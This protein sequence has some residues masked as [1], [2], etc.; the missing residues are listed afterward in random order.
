MLLTMTAALLRCNKRSR[1]GIVTNS[2]C[3]NILPPD[4]GLYTSQTSFLLANE[5][6]PRIWHIDLSPNKAYAAVVQSVPGDNHHLQVLYEQV[7]DMQQVL[8]CALMQQVSVC[9]VL[10]T[11]WQRISVHAPSAWM[12]GTAQVQTF[13]HWRSGL[14][15]THSCALW[16]FSWQDTCDSVLTITKSTAAMQCNACLPALLLAEALTGLLLMPEI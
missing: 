11:A 6:V 14:S 7:L 12:Q 1:V 8:V 9:S 3:C 10:C 5:G 2:I 4:A 15:R 13:R 16:I